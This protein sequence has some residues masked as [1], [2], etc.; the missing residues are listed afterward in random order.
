MELPAPPLSDIIALW[1]E[2]VLTAAGCLILLFD[3]VTNREQKRTLGWFTLWVCVGSLI[4]MYFIPAPGTSIFSGMFLADGYAT[5]FR[6]LFLLSTVLTV[7]ISLRHQFKPEIDRDEIA[8]A[9]HT[10][11]TYRCEQ[12]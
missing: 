7:L 5:F 4:L 12:Q 9:G 8:P 6:A 3:I 2:I 11:H 1:P 10:H